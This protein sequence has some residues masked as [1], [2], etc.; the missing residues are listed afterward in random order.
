MHDT[1][2]LTGCSDER[3]VTA[4]KTQHGREAKGLIVQIRYLKAKCARE[5][6]LRAD[7]GFQKDYLLVLLAQFEKRSVSNG[8]IGGQ[9]MSSNQQCSEQRILAAIAQVGFPVAP[10]TRPSKRRHTLRTAA[11][12]VMFLSRTK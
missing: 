2:R 6:A 3:A 11:L 4:L 9:S 5:G 12:A 7:L 8:K 1:L 10:P